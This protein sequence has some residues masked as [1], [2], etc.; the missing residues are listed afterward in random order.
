MQ[1]RNSPPTRMSD[2]STVV[3]NPCGDPC[4]CARC[5]FFVNASKTR[6][7]GASKMRVINSS[8]A[9]AGCDAPVSLLLLP[10]IPPFLFLHVGEVPVET[11]EAVLPEFPV[12]LDPVRHL[13]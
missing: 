4:H 3:V 2:R 6:S 12:V 9:A 10:D 1:M 11:T 7:R 8:S 13:A 5:S